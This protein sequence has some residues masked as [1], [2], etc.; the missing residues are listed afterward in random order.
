MNKQLHTFNGMQY[1]KTWYAGS[2]LTDTQFA[3]GMSSQLGA[4]YSHAMVRQYRQSLGIPGHKQPDERDTNIAALTQLCKDLF[5]A[6]NEPQI[7][8]GM[9]ICD[10]YK[11]LIS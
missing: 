3:A 5:S 11:A 9:R 7:A 4:A 2:D 6:T 10:E 1:V 8:F